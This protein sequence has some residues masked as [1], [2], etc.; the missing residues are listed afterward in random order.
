VQLSETTEKL[1]SFILPDSRSEVSKMGPLGPGSRGSKG[2][3]FKEIA[4]FRIEKMEIAA[5]HVHIFPQL[6]STKGHEV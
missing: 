5:D 4:G 6:P 3:L 2:G 1:C